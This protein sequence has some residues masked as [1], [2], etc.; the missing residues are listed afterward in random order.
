MVRGCVRGFDGAASSF[1]TTMDAIED[2]G[3]AFV[4]LLK[5]A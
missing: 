1:P 5:A 2:I 3:A 4:V